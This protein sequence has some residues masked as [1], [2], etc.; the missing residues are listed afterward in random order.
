VGEYVA[1]AS[2]SS[3][4][5]PTTKKCPDGS[6]ISMAQTCPLVVNKTPITGAVTAPSGINVGLTIFIILIVVVVVIIL[7]MWLF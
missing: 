7:K 2:G 4:Y 3:G 5:V 1:P 6:T